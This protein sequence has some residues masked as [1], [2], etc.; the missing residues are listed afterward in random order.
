MG[1]S[2]HRAAPDRPLCARRA[3]HPVGRR[4]PLPGSPDPHAAHHRRLY[5]GRPG[6][7]R[8][9]P[10]LGRH[11][12][13]RLSRQHGGPFL[14]AGLWHHERP[15]PARPDPG[16]VC[17]DVRR[18]LAPR[19]PGATGARSDT[20]TPR[21]RTPKTRSPN[22][23][24]RWDCDQKS[25]QG[26]ALSAFVRFEKRVTNRRQSAPLARGCPPGRGR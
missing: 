16:R 11:G 26:S 12:R 14:D 25:G 5:R 2:G 6:L 18:S 1:V 15:T 22:S 23:S 21:A 3:R 17:G 4:H 7:P 8:H 20:W 13:R 10:A 9:G 19:P 24:A